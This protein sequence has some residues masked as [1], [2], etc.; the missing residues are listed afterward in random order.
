MRLP[1]QHNTAPKD[2]PNMAIEHSTTVPL[3]VIDVDSMGQFLEK[4]HL[5]F[6]GITGHL[7]LANKMLSAEMLEAAGPSII[8]FHQEIATKDPL[9][10]MAYAQSLLAHARAAWLTKLLTEQTDAHALGIVSEACERAAGTLGRLTRAINEYRKPAGPATQVSISQGNQVLVQN[11]MKVDKHDEQ[12]GTEVPAKNK[13]VSFNAQGTTLP[14]AGSPKD[15]TVAMEHGSK[16][17]IRKVARCNERVPSRREI[18]RGRSKSKGYAKD[19]L[20]S[21]K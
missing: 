17:G 11:L 8:A 7:H 13:A 14:A 15:R 9:E 18:S 19:T 12:S 21:Q 3:G 10:R 16:N 5:D 4:A 2:T 1:N 6:V 20:I